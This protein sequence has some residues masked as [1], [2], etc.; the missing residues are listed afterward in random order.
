MTHKTEY[1][2]T[3]YQYPVTLVT[4]H[5]IRKSEQLVNKVGG[6]KKHNILA[7]SDHLSFK[8]Y[9]RGV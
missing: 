6:R 3:S 5:T 9:F 2:Y 4:I 1:C 8:I 7:N